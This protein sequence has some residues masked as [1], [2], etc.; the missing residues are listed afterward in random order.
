MAAAAKC[1]AQAPFQA[2]S[3]GLL[4]QG[5][6][7]VVPALSYNP[8][9]YADISGHYNACRLTVRPQQLGRTFNR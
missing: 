6:S 4:R 9:K 2:K 7:A 1:T 3:G 5:H 8:R